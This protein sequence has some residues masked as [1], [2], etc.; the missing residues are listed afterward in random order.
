[1]VRRVAIPLFGFTTAVLALS[2]CHNCGGG[3]F[4]SS[5]G[6]APCQLA[7][8]SGVMLDS[9]GMPIGGAPG[10]FVP[11]MPPGT[12]TELPYP[13]PNELIP[14]PGV[15]VPPAIPAPAPPDSSAMLPAPKFGTPVK[16]TK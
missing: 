8:R 10:A 7:G 15:P 4:T 13:Q 16:T 14:R 12:G 11:G 6:G 5:S 3:W 1:M 9:N 2:G